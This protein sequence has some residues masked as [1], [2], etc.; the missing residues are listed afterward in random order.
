MTPLRAAADGGHTDALHALVRCGADALTPSGVDTPTQT[1]IQ[2]EYKPNLEEA[3]V[4]EA[5]KAAEDA[6]GSGAAFGALREAW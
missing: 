6:Q 4:V 1:G 2:A 3:V 5:E